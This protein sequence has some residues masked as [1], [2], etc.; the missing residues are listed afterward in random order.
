MRRALPVLLLAAGILAAGCGQENRSLIPEDN[1]RALVENV[2]A[3]DAACSANDVDAAEDALNRVSDGIS[4]LPRRVDDDLQQ[5]M[6][7]WVEQVQGRLERDCEAE[8][9][10]ETPTA[11]ATPAETPTATPTETP[12]ATP[13]ETPTETPTATPTETPAPTVTPPPTE[14]DGG[15]GVVA[16]EI[17]PEGG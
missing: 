7:E 13:T 1:A 17:T 11:T 2:D 8:Q 9:E 4:E 6:R 16:P 15:G 5:N 12:T 10:E 3:V 14:D